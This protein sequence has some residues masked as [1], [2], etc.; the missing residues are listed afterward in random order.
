MDPEIDP[1][2][3]EAPTEG[4]TAGEGE[5]VEQV[6]EVE[7]GAANDD[8]EGGTTD[9]AEHVITLG[10]E[11]PA[12]EEEDETRAPAWVR[13]VRKTNRELVRKT[14]EQ[15]A[16]IARLKGSAG[17]TTPA[18]I[19]VGEKPTFENCEF[20][21]EKFETALTAWNERKAKAEAQENERT[22]QQKAAQATWE[23]R[24]A[25]V[26][27]EATKLRVRD[28]EGAQM[29]FDDTFSVLQRGIILSGPDDAKTS[30]QLRL[31]LGANPKVAKELAA[32][33]DPIKFTIRMTRIIDEMKMTTRKTAPIPERSVRGNVAGGAAVDK[34]L[35][36]L[37]K[38]AD[39]SGDRTKV[40]AHIRAVNER[41]R[42]AA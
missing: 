36:R 10:G 24:M 9:D 16:E 7:G 12:A 28:P 11:T 42:R 21:P 39:R 30:A 32:V 3:E 37:Q 14:R 15:E 19:V 13:D 20:D 26:D 31:A 6:E 25:A 23:K 18:A 41:A 22:T 17:T 8:S 27:A 5:T 35:E 29:V 33:T 4:E 38:E 1:I 40:A 2:E 34:T